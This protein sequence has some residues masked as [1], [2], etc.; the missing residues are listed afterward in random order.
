MIVT[1]VTEPGVAAK[2][3]IPLIEQAVVVVTFQ[4]RVV[5]TLAIL[6]NWSVSM[7]TN[8]NLRFEVVDSNK[9]YHIV[10]YLRKLQLAILRSKKLISSAGTSSCQRLLRV[11]TAD[12]DNCNRD[13]LTLEERGATAALKWEEELEK[14]IRSITQEV[15]RL[16]VRFNKQT[17]NAKFRSASKSDITYTY[18]QGA[19]TDWCV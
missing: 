1:V 15:L 13:R 4:P 10:I 2:Q 9:S 5:H 17:C 16:T 12:P 19:P 14:I 11:W 6:F 8:I 3:V 7:T 18:I